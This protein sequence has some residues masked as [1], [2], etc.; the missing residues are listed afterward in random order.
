MLPELSIAAMLCSEKIGKKFNASG[1][2]MSVNKLTSPNPHAQVLDIDIS[3]S[4]E[5]VLAIPDDDS[6]NKLLKTYVRAI[7]KEYGIDFNPLIG[8]EV[9]VDGI[10][11][12]I[13][14]TVG[15]SLRFELVDASITESL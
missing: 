6:S 4:L 15:N 2:L 9:S 7:I 8:K 12:S 13:N 11:E 5:I 1:I 14:I 3:N 10:L